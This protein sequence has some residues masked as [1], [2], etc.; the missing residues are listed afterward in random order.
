M[1]L[2][3]L[4]ACSCDEGCGDT[5][6]S[7]S[8]DTDTPPPV[9]DTAG[10]TAPDTSRGETGDASGDSTTDSG[11]S[12]DTGVPLPVD[13]LA[14]SATSADADVRLLG[15]V[16][17]AEAGWTVRGVGDVDGDGFADLLVGAHQDGRGGQAAGAAYLVLGPASSGEL[18]EPVLLGDHSRSYLGSTVDAA[19]DVDGDGRPDLLVG[20]PEAHL[21]NGI[22]TSYG[23]GEVL[24]FTTPFAGQQLAGD[25]QH[26]WRG[27]QEGARLGIGLGGVG[28]VDGDG[29]DDLVMG[30]PVAGANAEGAAF[31]VLGSERDLPLSEAH[32]GWE[33]TAVGQQLG[34]DADGAEDLNGDGY[35]DLWIGS[36]ADE[37]G[38]VGR[39]YG[40]YGGPSLAASGPIAP[41]V[42]LEG[43]H[44]DDTAGSTV[45]GADLDADGVGDVVVNAYDLHEGAAGG[46]AFVNHGP[47]SGYRAL[48]D[49]D[50]IVYGRDAETHGAEATGIAGD[51]DRDGFLDLVFGTHTYVDGF[52]AAATGQAFV[53]Y[54]PLSGEHAMDD[55]AWVATGASEGEQHGW[56]TTGVGDI[57]GDGVDDL[58][59]SAWKNSDSEGNGGAVYLWY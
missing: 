10:D 13:R 59:T 25:A 39:A 8:D 32:R 7:T 38:L 1:I 45:L 44:A 40:L 33:G 42:E 21:H 48:A 54:G 37:A 23:P 47:L 3:W 16:G 43:V 15:T 30:A 46:A 50:A 22:A 51:L 28:D 19:G 56:A 14:G 17:G 24:V 41:D 11:D 49:S 52:G 18:G 29:L 2:V 12:G 35:A 9:D 57:D 34:C 36:D 55:A 31:L 5:G 58:A 4:L 26:S 27:E 20:A 6:G 53:F